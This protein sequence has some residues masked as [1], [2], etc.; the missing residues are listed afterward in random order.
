MPCILL[1]ISNTCISISPLL[2][3]SANKHEEQPIGYS[4]DLGP[5]SGSCSLTKYTKLCMVW[6]PN[7][8]NML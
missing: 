1:R 6:Q 8:P 5:A 3:K 4:H 7:I 2:D